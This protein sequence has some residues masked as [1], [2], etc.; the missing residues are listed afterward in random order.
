MDNEKNPSDDDTKKK[1]FHLTVPERNLHFSK[2]K[3]L[4]F[5]FAH[6]A[7]TSIKYLT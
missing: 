6:L 1:H 4:L 7:E 2:N 3:L 5:S